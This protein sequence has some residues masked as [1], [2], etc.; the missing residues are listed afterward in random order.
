MTTKCLV[1]RGDAMSAVDDPLELL[2]IEANAD[3]SFRGR[4]IDG[5]TGRV[6]GG[7]VLAQSIRAGMLSIGDRRALAAV[8]CHFVSPSRSDIPI[9]Y[10]A[11]PIKTGRSLDVVTI[12][13]RQTG[14]VMMHSF[15]STHELEPSPEYADSMPDGPQ[16]ES[17][18]SDPR[19]PHD[20]N[21]LVRAPFDLRYVTE[22][23]IHAAREDLWF[24]TRRPV[25][26][27]AHGDHSA[28]LAYAVDF[29]VSRSAHLGLPDNMA[30]IG[31]SL[32]HAMWFHR[33]FRIDDWLFVRS[34]ASSFAG[35]R[36]LATSQIFDRQGRLVATASQSALIRAA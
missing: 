19:A 26:S 17:L 24:R 14:R 33:P 34:Q 30:A 32:D 7:H 28:L 5:V 31:A 29:M 10:E 6:F 4:C 21:P 11:D 12:T 15:L 1:V 2:S 22:P 8:H 16:P 3:G 18:E 36:S 27:D 35:S 20:T 9:E 25:S 23:G 13:A